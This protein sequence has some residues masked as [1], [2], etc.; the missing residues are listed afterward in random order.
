MLLLGG[1]TSLPE[2]AAVS[3]SA[4]AGNGTCHR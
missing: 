4:Y 1:I 2:I 3:T